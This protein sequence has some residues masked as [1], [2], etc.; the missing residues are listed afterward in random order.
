MRYR[1]GNWQ[2]ERHGREINYYEDVTPP[3]PPGV[4]WDAARLACVIQGAVPGLRVM[5][6]DDGLYHL[7]GYVGSKGLSDGS[8]YY[9]VGLYAFNCEDENCLAGH[10]ANEECKDPDCVLTLLQGDFAEKRHDLLLA[11]VNQTPPPDYVAELDPRIAAL[12]A[13]ELSLSLIGD[14]HTHRRVRKFIATPPLR[15][16]DIKAIERAVGSHPQFRLLPDESH[17][18]RVIESWGV[19][20]DGPFAPFLDP[21]LPWPEEARVALMAPA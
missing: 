5:H 12:R 13:N 8:L 21:C 10:V 17:N 7:H 4:E 6:E 14:K 18:R 16:G 2:N 19:T 20:A 15:R 1:F 9:W 11:K 3:P